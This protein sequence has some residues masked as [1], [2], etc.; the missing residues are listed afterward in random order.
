MNFEKPSINNKEL[1]NISLLQK[2]SILSIDVVIGSVLCGA[3]VIQVLD[4][5]PGFAWWIVLPISV[6]IIYTL[7][8]MI[9]GYRLKEN[10]HTYRHYFHFK[11]IK[12]LAYVILVLS[13]INL[14]L[15]FFFL[16][17]QILMFGL[18]AALVTGLYLLGVLLFKKK[19]SWF[20]HAVQENPAYS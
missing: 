5:E 20:F 17:K 10:A 2:L 19:R 14:I 6:W 16:E 1:L 4:M 3:F 13:A 9:D 12:P 8:H 7:D 18:F 11:Y 15:V